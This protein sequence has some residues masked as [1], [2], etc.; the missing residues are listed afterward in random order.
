MKERIQNRLLKI[1][2]DGYGNN[3]GLKN[4]ASIAGIKKP[5]TRKLEIIE[6]LCDYYEN[7]ST[8][9]QIYEKL[10]SYEKDLVT[11]IIHRRYKPLT[12]D[13][14]QVAKQHNFKEKSSSWYGTS[15]KNY[16]PNKSPLYIIFPDNYIAPY[17][18]EYLDKIVPPYQFSIDIEE[19]TTEDIKDYD[20]IIGREQRLK[21]F[22]LLLSFINSNTPNATKS[23]GYM[24][25][26]ALLKF[27]H[28]AGYEDIC[29]SDSGEID[30]IRNAGETIIS[31][32]LIEL[33]KNADVI[34]VVN[35]KFTLSKQA[36]HFATLPLLEKAQFLYRHYVELNTYI[37]DE[38]TRIYAPK[39]RF[40]KTVYDLADIRRQVIDYLKL[41]PQ[42]EWIDFNKFS[43]EVRKINASLFQD[44]GYVQMWDDYHKYYYDCSDWNTFEHY[45]LSIILMEYLTTLGAIDVLAYATERGTYG[46]DEAYEVAYFKITDLGAYLFKMTNSYTPKTE[47]QDQSDESGLM[48][49]PNLEISIRSGIQRLK[50]ELFF[51]RFANK[52]VDEEHVAIYKLEF[53]GLIEALDIG[54]SIQ[55]IQ[56]YCEQFAEEDIPDNVKDAFLEWQ[57]QSMSIRIRTVSIIESDDPSLLE[58]IGKYKGMEKFLESNNPKPVLIL[59]SGMEKKAKSQ[60]EKN[61]QFCLWNF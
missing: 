57:N 35:N 8:P 6:A 49:H 41:C 54:I 16:F 3:V 5:P 33:L 38:C 17:F 24:S 23:N 43:K 59:K 45:A 7:P 42:N 21:D 32:G 9:K 53:K 28:L 27:H 55:E 37:I 46:S 30:D 48:V 13:L 22:E 50:H 2:L 44:V 19:I 20:T 14:A 4:L 34:T 47:E 25:K 1:N 36:S 18:K 52:I 15:F 61:K 10:T 58:K 51:D 39:L 31:T 12:E 56:D 60:I 26:S 29:N 11:C 40:S